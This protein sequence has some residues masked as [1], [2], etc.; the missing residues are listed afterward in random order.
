MGA[1]QRAAP[2]RK[3]KPGAAQNNRNRNDGHNTVTNKR[4][5]ARIKHTGRCPACGNEDALDVT[6]NPRGGWWIGCYSCEAE[7]VT[8]GDLLRA[9]AD[10]VGAPGGGDI[11]ADPFRWLRPYL[12]SAAKTG[13]VA[14]M[15]TEA[16]VAGWAS[17]L[18]SD[19]R[20]LYYLE[21]KRGLTKAT[22][23]RERLGY[24]GDLDAVVIPVYADGALV[25]VRRRY[26]SPAPGQ[27]KYKGLAGRSGHLYPQPPGRNAVVLCAGE[28]DALLTLQHGIPAVTSTLGAGGWRE[29]WD[30]CFVG[31]RVAV[32]FDVGEEKAMRKRVAQLCAAGARAS[33]VRLS[34]LGGFTGKDLTDALTG[35]STADDLKALINCECRRPA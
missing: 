15:P 28:F 22:I 35:G 8:G 33:A 29:D 1:K 24:D 27:P 16:A 25:N 32:C 26:L 31:R 14:S 2:G 34:R 17:R 13:Y 6:P 12:D 19:E 20:A 5:S 30:A 18:F 3:A 4:S 9:L 10:T 21:E 11:K 7:G 23:C